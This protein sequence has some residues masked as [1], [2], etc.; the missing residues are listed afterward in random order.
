MVNNTYCDICGEETGY[1]E[2][3]LIMKGPRSGHGVNIHW[4]L[5]SKCGKAIEGLVRGYK[6]TSK[7]GGD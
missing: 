3:L 6:I 5:C 1:Y 2:I 7:K 4:D